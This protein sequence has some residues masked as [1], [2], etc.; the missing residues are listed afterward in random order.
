MKGVL[1][2]LGRSYAATNGAGY[3]IRHAHNTSCILY[4]APGVQ[5]WVLPEGQDS[6]AKEMKMVRPLVRHT[7]CELILSK[8]AIMAM[9][10]DTF[11]SVLMQQ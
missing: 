5:D 9:V 4:P 7:S 2:V 6:G 1:E 10:C 8:I 11:R 3:R